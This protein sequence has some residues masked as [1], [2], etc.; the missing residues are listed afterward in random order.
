MTAVCAKLGMSRQ[1]YYA[2]RRRRQARC[3]EQ[4]RILDWTRAQRASQPKLGTR[5][6]HHLLKQG[7]QVPPIGRDRYFKLLRDN[8][9]LVAYEPTGVR[10]TNSYHT[11]PV[12]TN[13]IRERPA[14]GPNEV[15]LCDLTYLRTAEGFSYLFLI[16]DQYSRKIVGHHLSA[17]MEAADALEALG[18]ATRQLPGGCKPIHHS[19][20][21]CQYCCHDYLKSA[22]RAGVELSMTERD[23]CAENAQAE[24]VNGI[25]KQEYALGGPLPG[26]TSTRRMVDQ[27]VYLYNHHR[28]HLSLGMDFPARVHARALENRAAP[29]GAGSPADN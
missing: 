24:R 22:R 26:R 6:L 1:N 27:A 15:W 20:R 18:Q 29:R 16:S 9:M 2:Q 4:A 25:L 13:Q 8:E 21:G 5:K 12:F 14:Q 7:E 10:T 11:L 3:F 19:D 23:H 17:T 28:P